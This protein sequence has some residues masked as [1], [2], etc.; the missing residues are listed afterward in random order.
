MSDDTMLYASYT[1]GFKAGGFDARS[2]SN[3]NFEFDEELAESYELGAK[4]SLDDG[5]AE[6]N[7]A[8]YRTEY[9]DLQTSQFDGA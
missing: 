7:I 2:N 5:A 6:L 9:T 3:A 1:E 4:M 8:L